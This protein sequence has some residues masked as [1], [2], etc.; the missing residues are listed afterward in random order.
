[1]RFYFLLGLGID[2]FFIV[3]MASA[4]CATKKYYRELQI[5]GGRQFQANQRI[6]PL[7]TPLHFSVLINTMQVRHRLNRR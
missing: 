1:M 4:L 7:N 3:Y 5:T 6:H 2:F